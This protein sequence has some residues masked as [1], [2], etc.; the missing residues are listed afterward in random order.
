MPN[1]ASCLGA[2]VYDCPHPELERRILARAETSGR[3]DDNLITARKRFDTFETQ[4]MPVVRALEEVERAE[5][6]LSSANKGG[7]GSG[8]GSGCSRVRVRHIGGVGTIEEVWERTRDALDDF[9]LNDV[10]TAN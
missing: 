10:L 1:A 4:T 6:E 7:I 2:L 8:G 3:S 9:V 5:I